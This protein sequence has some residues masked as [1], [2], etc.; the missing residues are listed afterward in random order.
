VQISHHK[1]AGVANRGKVRESLAL[2]DG[3]VTGGVPPGSDMYPYLAGSST[4]ISLFPPWALEGGL[5][6]LLARLADP[7]SRR[8]IESDFTTGL[9]GW[10]NRAK[11][12]GWEN[13]FVSSA[14][15]EARAL[16]GKNL[17]EIAQ[18]RGQ[19]PERAA[20]DLILAERGRV[21]YIGFNSSEEDLETMLRHPR[22][23]IGSDGLDVGERPHPRLYGTFPRVLGEYVRR[24]G[25]LTV[26][27]AVHKMTGL[28]ARQLRLEGIGLIRPGY[29]ADLVLFDPD[30]V[31]DRAT[32]E[33]P[34][35]FPVGI[36]YVLVAGVAVVEH[37]RVTGALPGQVLRRGETP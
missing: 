32:F 36:P 12:S 28:T 10:E 17:R 2:L 31:E 21:G 25:V 20:C 23:S 29:R 5:P 8:R 3:A 18:A 7:E 30:T 16:V 14:A 27:Q 4:L 37:E 6:A 11:V 9:P 19:P 24:R 26:E 13:L 35:E 1:C 33:Q 34:R 15:G 22:T